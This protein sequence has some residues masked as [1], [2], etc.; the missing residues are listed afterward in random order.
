MFNSETDPKL[1]EQI[2]TYFMSSV[3][4]DIERAKALGLPKDCRIREGAKII[5]P[6][7]LEIGENVWIGENAVL[8]ASG[9][10]KIGSH[11]QIGLGVYIWTHDSHLAAILGKNTLHDKR[12]IS[13]TS[14]EIGDNCYIG[15][16]S[17]IM[18]GAK[19]GE[20][21]AVAPMSVLYGELPAKKLYKPYRDMVD[22][23]V[24]DNK[25]KALEDRITELEK[26]LLAK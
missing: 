10:L 1:R 23:I 20:R 8:D 12:L 21:S 5:C 9:G 17:V 22:T 15:G 6:E 26:K 11:V 3:M 13:R 14:T 19:M 25:I 2:L 24:T 4:T 7:N 16:P 18:P